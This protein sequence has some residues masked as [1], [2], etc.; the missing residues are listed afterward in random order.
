MGPPVSNATAWQFSSHSPTEN[1]RV[2]ERLALLLSHIIAYFESDFLCSWSSKSIDFFAAYS[3]YS[4]DCSES[5]LNHSVFAVVTTIACMA[6]AMYRPV[7]GVFRLFQNSA[8]N[9][10]GDWRLYLLNYYLN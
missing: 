2:R 6:P 9:E 8:A 3:E 10:V 1:F 7:D 5:A 4:S